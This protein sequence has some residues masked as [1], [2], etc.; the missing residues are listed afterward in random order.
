MRKKILII[1]ILFIYLFFLTPI[2]YNWD[3]QINALA[4]LIIMQILWIGRVLPYVQS[5]LILIIL[6]S[7]HFYPFEK[8][9][10]YLGTG[11]VWLVF[12]TYI[13]SKAFMKSGLAQRFSLQI[14]R[15]SRGSGKLLLLS[16]YI[17]MIVLAVIIPSN[18]G[19]TSLIASSLDQIIKHLKTLMKVDNL[20]KSMFVGV[21]ILTGISGVLVTT[22]ASSTIYTYGLLE[23]SSSFNI[24]YIYWVLFFIIPVILFIIALWVVSLFVLP[25]ENVDK[26]YLSSYINSK[27]SE[28]GPMS[29]NEIKMLCII[30]VTVILWVFNSQLHLSI[31]MVGILGALLTLMPYIGIWE[32]DE[33]QK[34]VNWEMFLFF[35]S[36]LMLS[37]MLI[38]S[39]IL[40]SFTKF[41]LPFF[42]ESN[43]FLTILII[44]IVIMLLRTI[45]VNVL[46][47]LT[48]IIPLALTLGSQLNVGDPT[49]FTMAIFLAGVPGFFLVTQSPSHIISYSYDY[50]TSADLFKIGSI[51]SIIWI[52]IIMFSVFVLWPLIIL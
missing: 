19:R 52:L 15:L 37:N 43:E 10:G 18:I 13:I 9:V 8:V 16:S 4:L 23:E 24:T 40:E 17:L 2:F 27:L 22:G 42:E 7:I 45:F 49:L 12:A 25:V 11:I 33:A 44:I 20:A 5:T 36:T 28:L 50:F 32:W 41:L 31:P 14:I 39:G 29:K 26:N 21:A 3:I 34:S 1:L 47:F 46:G 38:D 48:I 30:V 51:L 35:G 6:L